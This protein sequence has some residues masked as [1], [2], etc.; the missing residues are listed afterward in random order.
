MVP[1]AYLL[2]LVNNCIEISFLVLSLGGGQVKVEIRANSAQPTEL[3]LDWA[4]LSLATL[5]ESFNFT[6]LQADIGWTEKDSME[7]WYIYCASQSIKSVSS[8]RIY[9]QIL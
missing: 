8:L 1:Q 2:N 3:E 5:S 7:I 9:P 6:L 4:G